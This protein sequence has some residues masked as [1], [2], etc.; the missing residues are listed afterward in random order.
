MRIRIV[1]GLASV[2]LPLATILAGCGSD[3]A[4]SSCAH[5]ALAT[6][7][8]FDNGNE[9][10]V[11][12]VVA[13]ENVRV[14]RLGTK[15]YG[16]PSGVFGPQTVQIFHRSGTYA[17][18]EDSSTGWTLAGTVDVTSLGEAVVTQ[19]PIDLDIVLAVGERHAFYVTAQTAIG[20]VKYSDGT[21]LDAVA[22][23]D[24]SLEIREG[25]GV[26][27]PFLS[28]GLVRVFNGSVLYERCP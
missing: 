7:R 4:S 23:A 18:F 14:L 17:G 20:G 11:F 15:L 24:A 6:T 19:I 12:D 8:A 21:S 26:V 2:L 9:G 25:E 10:I 27:Y 22:D 3:D 1:S 13:R 28:N 5:S 16:E